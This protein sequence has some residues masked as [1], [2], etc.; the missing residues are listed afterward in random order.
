MG[1]D[2]TRARLSEDSETFIQRTCRILSGMF[3][4]VI[5]VAGDPA[6]FVGCKFTRCVADVF[7]DGGPLGGIYTGLTAVQK[8]YA[9][10]V[11][12]D[13]PFLSESFIRREVGRHLPPTPL[14]E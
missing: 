5:I 1:F 8:N 11:S 9:L 13:L 7:T 10:F 6:R 2:K 14:K 4:E 12:T 3:D